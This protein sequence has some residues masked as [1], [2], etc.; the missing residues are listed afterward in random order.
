MIYCCEH[1][2]IC[3][4]I[5][6][7]CERITEV[8]VYVAL[9]HWPDLANVSNVYRGLM[10]GADNTT[11]VMSNRTVSINPSIFTS[12]TSDSTVVTCMQSLLSFP[13]EIDIS[14]RSPVL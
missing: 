5:M 9:L 12:A 3:L 7:I 11:S 13:T 6:H 4:Y 8:F 14:A 1:I 10:N 2:K